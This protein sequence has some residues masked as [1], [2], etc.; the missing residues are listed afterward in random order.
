MP[1]CIAMVAGA[2]V[3]ATSSVHAQT[4]EPPTEPVEIG[5]KLVRVALSQKAADKLSEHRVRRLVELQVGGGV[6]VPNESFGPLDENAV[7]VFIDL[8]EPTV[9]LVQVQ[10]PERRLEVQRVDVAGLPWEVATRFVAIAA[11][12]SVRAQIAPRRKPRPR[13]PTPDEIAAT[14]SK[15][16]AFELEAGLELAYVSY[17]ETGLAGTRLQIAFHQPALSTMVS[18]AFFATFDGGSWAELD[19][20]VGRRFWISPNL[21]AGFDLGFALALT[22][23]V[24]PIQEASELWVRPHLGGRFDVRVTERAWINFGVEPGITVDPGR[25]EA[26]LWIGGGAQLSFESL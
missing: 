14:L 18:A 1:V 2:V 10:A 6:V 8:P 22:K 15:K 21:R 23:D 25:R 7:R 20:A 3:F 4:A 9:V 24:L 5:P 13:P 16:P 17:L 11:S 26:G 19:T 12:Q